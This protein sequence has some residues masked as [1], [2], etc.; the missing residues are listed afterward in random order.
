MIRSSYDSRDI[1]LR[2]TR[3][4]GHR[5]EVLRQWMAA[6]ARHAP[7][8]EVRRALDLG[9]GTGR[10]LVPLA[11]TY[12]DAQVVG[13]DV[14]AKMLSVAAGAASARSNVRLTR[15]DAQRLP[16][17]SVSLDLVFVSMIFHHV[18]DRAAVCREIARV[19]RPHRDGAFVM[20][21]CCLE[22]FDSFLYSHFFPEAR[23]IDLARLQPA[24]AVI[25]F[26]SQHGLALTAHEAITQVVADSPA[27]YVERTRMRAASDLEAITDEQFAAGMRHLEDHCRT[28]DPATPITET[29]DL[30]VFRRSS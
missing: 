24:G 9:C 30:L 3:G 13:M 19:L 8:A 27:E 5:P 2:Y 7:P 1:H 21:T 14:S 29:V 26:I 25:G 16:I 10:F 4:R 18:P 15:A 6:V 20:R 11:A 28:M 23:A 22:N 12:Q 17:E